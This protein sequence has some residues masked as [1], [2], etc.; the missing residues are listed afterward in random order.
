[1][2][3]ATV[4][5][6]AGGLG[7]G[8]AGASMT[9]AALPPS[10]R[11][12]WP[13]EDY[14]LVGTLNSGQAFRWTPGQDGWRGVVDSRWIRVR[15]C[16]KALLAEVAE[17]CAHWGWFSDYFQVERELGRV[18]ATFP[19]DAPMR[20]ALAACRGLR[21]LRQDPWECLASFIC[22]STKQIVQ[23]RE[24]VRLLCERFGR[25]LPVPAGEAAAYSFPTASVL[26]RAPIPALRECKLG[27]RAAY[28]QAT[29]RAV[30]GGEIPLASLSSLP[31]NEARARLMALPGVGPK[32]ADC[33]LLFACGFQEAFP[34][35]VWVEKA[36]RRLYFPERRVSAKQLREFAGS[37]FG[38]CSGYAQQYLF[39]YIRVHARQST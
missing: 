24:M 12:E 39:H 3:D 15:T 30:A 22:S 5:D 31:V 18:I 20:A 21:L 35:D 8:H 1:M 16:G 28:L 4:Q 29:A 26:A 10:M 36:L 7:A 25:R 23:I 2:A 38:P 34:V 13:V 17:P 9:R 27:F 14:D 11:T 32:I 37:H 33:V 6:Q 19:D